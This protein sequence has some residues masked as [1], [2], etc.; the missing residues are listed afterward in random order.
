[1]GKNS[2]SLLLYTYVRYKFFLNIVR[3]R[4]REF[5]KDTTQ[6]AEQYK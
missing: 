4:E 6:L 3:E 5:I 2:I 1:M